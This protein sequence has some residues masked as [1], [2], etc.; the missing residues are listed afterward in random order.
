M[1][2]WEL[3][4]LGSL[5]EVYDGPHATPRKTD[6][7]PWYLSIA[8][9]RS[10]QLDLAESAHISVSDYPRWSRRVAPEAGDTLFSYETRLGES[11]YWDRN[12]PAVL[13]RRMGLL[14]PDPNTV[15]PRFLSLAYESP[16]FQ[17]EITKRSI[18]G[19][20]VNRIPISDMGNWPIAVPGL[21][22]QRAIAEAIGALDE[23]AKNNERLATALED[24][25]HA[26]FERSGAANEGKHPLENYVEINPT[27]SKPTGPAPFVDMATLSTKRFGVATFSTRIDAGGTRFRAGDCLLARITPSLENGKAAFITE[28]P[29]GGTAVGSTEFIVLQSRAGIPPIWPYLLSRAER[30][31]EYA[32]RHMTGTSGRQRLSAVSVAEFAIDAPRPEDLARL[33]TMA[34][35]LVPAINSLHRELESIRRVRAEIFPLLMSGKVRVSADSAK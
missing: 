15:D 33:S 23:Y 13:G 25:M 35:E 27:Y 9:L 2:E 19:A 10:G 18:Q 4:P 17:N 3:V 22:D 20:T 28:V 7:G 14:R 30:F 26:E 6:E 29:G 32:I 11:A 8:S 21:P 24:T 1:S 16:M 31:R 34:A 5:C 12:D